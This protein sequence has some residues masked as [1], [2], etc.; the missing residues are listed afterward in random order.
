MT[1]ITASA[2]KQADVL[3][4]LLAADEDKAV[5]EAISRHLAPITR[6]A[7][8]SISVLDDFS[9]PGGSDIA[10][11]KNQLLAADI[12]LSIISAD[13]IDDD[14]IY[15]RNQAV[16]DRYN[17]GETLIISI[18][19]RNCLWKLLPLAQLPMLPKNHQPINN[20]QFWNSEDDAV[21][22][23]VADLYESISEM[24]NKAGATVAAAPPETAPAPAPLPGA[25]T[26]PAASADPV[27]HVSL[28]DAESAT[29]E[30]VGAGAP[31]PG[32]S[33]PA[34]SL[35]QAPSVP[36]SAEEVTG[37]TVAEPDVVIE[38]PAPEA[39]PAAPE[40]VTADRV[41]TD[42]GAAQTG[43]VFTK[44]AVTAPIEVDW[45][46][47]YYRWVLGKRA[48]AIVLDFVI[49]FFVIPFTLAFVYFMVAD[50]AGIGEASDVTV[51]DWIFY[52]CIAVFYLVAPALEASTW[53]AT[54][55]KRILKLQITTEAGERISYRRAFVRNVLRS[56]TAYSYLLVVPLIIQYFR[57]RK[58]KQLFHDEVSSTTIG[59]RLD[60]S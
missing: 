34:G 53:Q 58:T 8:V 36:A 2:E 14:E 24:L 12:V 60:E 17:R 15:A 35:A 30:L 18:L 38:L 45:R 3:I 54:P 50:F 9:A 27:V 47:T 56:L 43:F 48:L 41:A 6:D 5:C 32:S 23:V 26:P 20:A 51:M 33:D 40:T 13:F 37:Q 1:G 22:S 57:F 46:Q 31:G 10:Q 52:L 49:L 42:T 21:T 25:G 4:Y 44:P 19:V 59:E 28:T 11:H 39:A 55:G 7:D 16:I 29:T